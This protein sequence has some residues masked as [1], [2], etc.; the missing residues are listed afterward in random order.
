MSSE[1]PSRPQDSSQPTRQQL[2]EL[3][4]LLQRMLDLPVNKLDDGQGVE[5]PPPGADGTGAAASG[6]TAALPEVPRPP[7]QYVV[8]E[9]PPAEVSSGSPGALAAQA[10]PSPADPATGPD[11]PDAGDWV[12]LRSAWRPSAQTWGPLAESWW[13]AQSGEKPQP[14]GTDEAPPPEPPAEAISPDTTPAAPQAPAAMPK[15]PENRSDLAVAR[16]GLLARP[17]L[18][19]NR[20]FY[21]GVASLGAPGRWLAG[22]A[23]RTVLGVLGLAFLTAAVALSLAAGK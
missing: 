2:D 1:K 12:P 13:Q 21:R 3:D 20:A 8:V 14:A 11:A 16:P 7:V 23:G 19:F 17:L 10:P 9:T 6:L 15:P 4:A 18:G 22:P 5:A